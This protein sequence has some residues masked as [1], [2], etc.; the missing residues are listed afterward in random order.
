M[1]IFEEGDETGVGQVLAAGQGH[2]LNPG[3]NG[4]GQDGAI[5]DLVSQGSE[6]EALDKFR[7]GK[8]GGLEP[9]G[10]AY[11]RELLPIGAGWTQPENLD[12]I[13]RPFLADQHAR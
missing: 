4:Q 6:V 10:V 5:V 8:R 12:D 3:T 2:A 13:A 7:I 9:Q 1:I 11:C